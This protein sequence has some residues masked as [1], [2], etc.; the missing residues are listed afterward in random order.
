MGRYILIAVLL[1]SSQ[2]VS[3]S[4]DPTAPLGWQN[5][6]QRKAKTAAQPRP[7]QLQSIVCNGESA[8]KATLSDQVVVAGESVRGY[9]VNNIK[10]ESVVLSRGGKQWT[11]ELFSLDI[12]Q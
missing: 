8:C 3:A 2:C 12:K 10:P 6:K 1:A 5:A 4:Q 7:P 9:R 11:L